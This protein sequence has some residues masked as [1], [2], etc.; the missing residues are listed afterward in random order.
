MAYTPGDF[1]MEHVLI[2]WGG[3]LPGGESW[4]CSLR[5]GAN[6]ADPLSAD[7]PSEDSVA[8]WL[9]GSIKDAVTAYHTRVTTGINPLATLTFIKANRINK[10][11]HYKDALTHEVVLAPVA[12]AGNN[13]PVLPNQ[14]TLA[15]SLT[16]GFTRGP[17]H[18]GRFYLPLPT[19]QIVGNTGQ[20]S[21]GDV[22][23]IRNSTKTFIEAIADVP[24][25]DAPFSQTPTVFSRKQGAAGHRAITGVEVG[26]VID[27]QRRR[28]RNVKEDYASAVL[29]LGAF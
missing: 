16:T 5:T 29:N 11:G 28:R 18:R 14:C 22:Q 20:I 21:D 4:S 12:G 19:V 25:V 3:G 23:N 7:V 26:R 15:I 8:A 10:Q 27:T 17:A 24:G 13:G 1:D 2:Q 9:T 6:T